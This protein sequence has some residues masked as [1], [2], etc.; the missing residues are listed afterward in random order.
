MLFGRSDACR[1][2][3][4]LLSALREGAGGAHVLNGPPGIGKTALLNYAAN[5]AAICPVLR[6]KGSPGE[7][8]IAYAGLS[9]VSRRCLTGCLPWLYLKLPPFK[10]RWPLAHLPGPTSFRSMRQ[11]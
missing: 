4:A 3:D 7:T 6:A 8:A 1:R 11:L 10:R 5:G 9:Q 2:I